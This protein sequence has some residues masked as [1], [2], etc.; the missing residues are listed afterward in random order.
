MHGTGSG[1]WAGERRT[2]SEHEDVLPRRHAHV[3]ATKDVAG[4]LLP[5]VGRRRVREAVMHDD[6]HSGALAAEGLDGDGVQEGGDVEVRVPED[7]GVM[8]LLCGGV[9]R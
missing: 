3:R 1:G 2:A 8:Q 5:G 7:G 4:V 6:V 9:V